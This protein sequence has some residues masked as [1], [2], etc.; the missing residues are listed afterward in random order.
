MNSTSNESIV[1]LL[2]TC[3]ESGLAPDYKVD[4]EGSGCRDFCDRCD[5]TGCRTIVP[6]ESGGREV[7]VISDLHMASGLDEDDRYTG[8]ENFFSDG[9]FARFIDKKNDECA[10]TGGLP[11]FPL[12]NHS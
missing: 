10:E 5:D 12:S 1:H 8:N 4:T 3:E 11:R 9:P 7:I 2:R 6:V